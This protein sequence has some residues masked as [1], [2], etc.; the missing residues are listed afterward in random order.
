LQDGTPEQQ[1]AADPQQAPVPGDRPVAV[2]D[3]GTTA[4]EQYEGEDLDGRLSREEPDQ[5]VEPGPASPG[6]TPGERHRSGRLVAPSQGAGPDEDPDETALE[7]G[8][9]RGGFS[10]EEDAMRVEP[11]S[12]AGP[13]EETG[14]RPRTA[15]D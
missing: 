1:W 11:E 5:Q 12:D 15:P 8:P 13:I 4:Q 2:D 6:E 3:F 14:S 9:D 10:A 7:V